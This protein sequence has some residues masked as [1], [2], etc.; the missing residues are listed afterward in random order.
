MQA[1]ERFLK[2]VYVC[3]NGCHE[4][5]S[6]IKRDGYGQFWF[7]GKPRKAHKIAYEFFKGLVPQGKL[8]LHKC[9]NKICVNPEHLYVG[10]HKDNARDAVE[11]GQYVSRAKLEDWEAAEIRERYKTR[12][13][14]QMQLAREYG[15]HQGSISKVILGKT[16]RLVIKG[17]KS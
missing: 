12:G 3:A 8:V 13:I 1:K 16:Y 11:R 17:E 7:D 4:W 15:V 2:Y 6:T 10:T 5:R 14:T 9:D